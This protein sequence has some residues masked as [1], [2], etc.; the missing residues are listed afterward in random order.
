MLKIQNKKL[1]KIDCECS[2]LIVKHYLSNR[3]NQTYMKEKKKKIVVSLH[4]NDLRLKKYNYKTR[5]KNKEI[6]KNIVILHSCII[7]SK[8]LCT[9]L[10]LS[11]TQ[12]FAYYYQY[13]DEDNL[14]I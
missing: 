12:L 2:S 6:F 1:K 14:K 3:K 5:L 10:T 11:L 7:L 8:L 13:Y 4:S 9:L